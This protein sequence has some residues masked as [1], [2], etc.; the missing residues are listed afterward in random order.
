MF[1]ENCV[2]LDSVQ[3]QQPKVAHFKRACGVSVVL[4]YYRLRFEVLMLVSIMSH[5][6]TIRPTNRPCSP[7]LFTGPPSLSVILAV[8]HKNLKFQWETFMKNDYSERH[9]FHAL[10]PPTRAL[11]LRKEDHTSMA[12]LSFN[13]ISKVLSKHNIKTGSPAKEALQFSSSC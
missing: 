9:I 10:N 13:R 6:T 5:L 4:F 7:P 2:H 8:F 11:P 1:T 3:F 12:F